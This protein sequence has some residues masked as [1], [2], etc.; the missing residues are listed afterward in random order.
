MLIRDERPIRYSTF[1]KESIRS[2]LE[3]NQSTGKVCPNLDCDGILEIQACRGHCGYPVTHF[4]R[5]VANYGILFQVRKGS[6]YS[7]EAWVEIGSSI[8][9]TG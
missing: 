8:S 4:W 1:Y 5:H 7:T 3:Y 6:Q 9:S 2:F